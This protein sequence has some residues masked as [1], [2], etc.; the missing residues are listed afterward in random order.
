MN[1]LLSEAFEEKG[2][3]VARVPNHKK[4]LKTDRSVVR[5]ENWV[6]GCA[7]EEALVKIK[8]DGSIEITIKPAG[9]F[10]GDEIREFMKSRGFRFITA[11]DFPK[12]EKS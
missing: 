4:H 6:K 9:V 8:A 12:K 7:E 11:F 1:T 10:S 3:E 5:Q 2:L